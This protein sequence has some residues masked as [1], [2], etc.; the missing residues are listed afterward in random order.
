MWAC[1]RHPP[2]QLLP[3]SAAGSVQGSQMQIAM[4]QV[5][6]GGKSS[7]LPLLSLAAAAEQIPHLQQ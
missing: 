1:Q 4:S 2:A 3:L 6:P 5:T 7:V